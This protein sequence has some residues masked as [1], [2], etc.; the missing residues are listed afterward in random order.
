MP[1]DLSFAVLGLGM[2][3]NHCQAIVDA[4]GARLAAVCDHDEARL[5][6]AT[7]KFGCEGYAKYAD[8]LKNRDIDAVC[9]ATESGLHAK[10]GIQAARAGKHLL[11]EKPVDI[12]PARIKQLRDVVEQTGVK[13]GCVFQSRTEPLNLRL[14]KAIDDGKLGKL[15]GVHAQLPWFR[16][17]SYYEGPHGSWKGT[18]KLDG[19]GSLMNQGIHTVDLIQWL[20]GPVESV[21]GF[22]GVFGH[23]IEAEDQ[24]V[25]ILKFECGALGTLVTTTC[26]IPDQ[27]QRILVYGEKGSFTKTAYLEHFEA[28]SKRERQQ[29]MEWYGQEKISKLGRDPLAVGSAGHV[30]HV[31]DLVKAIRRNSKPAITI[32]DAT[33]PVE[34]ACAIFKSARTGKVVKVKDMRR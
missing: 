29:M 24:T 11:V 33:H 10:H 22:T 21:C 20:A 27:S 1:K 15:I 16:A 12:T 9:I 28:G 26:T 14:K 19:G 18:W 25:A 2:G 8:L 5:K 34:I 6:E 3:M 4:N 30:R 31:E 7:T 13:C 17:Q 23:K 32:E